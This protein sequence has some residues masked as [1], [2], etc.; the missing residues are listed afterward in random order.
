MKNII[1]LHTRY[2]CKEEIIMLN[3]SSKRT[4]TENVCPHFAIWPPL[5]PDSFTQLHNTQKNMIIISIYV[6]TFISFL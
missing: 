6:I 4:I 2:F 1:S 3:K 5:Q